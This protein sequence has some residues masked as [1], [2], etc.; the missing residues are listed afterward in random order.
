MSNI[1]PQSMYHLFVSRINA[2]AGIFDANLWQAST[3]TLP[4]P[5]STLSLETAHIHS[6]STAQERYDVAT[7]NQARIAAIKIHVLPFECRISTNG[8][9]SP[10][11]PLVPCSVLSS[12]ALRSAR[13][14]PAEA[15]R[16]PLKARPLDVCIT[17]GQGSRTFSL[18]RPLNNNNL[19]LNPFS[20]ELSQ[21]G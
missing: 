5:T 17:S 16:D 18:S 21:N 14:A 10:S 4:T 3:L 19:L 15:D 6:C 7:C 20:K 9:T 11:R 2:V 12:E 8:S 13:T 1:L